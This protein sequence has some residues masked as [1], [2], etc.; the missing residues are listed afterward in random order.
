MILWENKANNICTE[1]KKDSINHTTELIFK[2][3]KFNLVCNFVLGGSLFSML[4]M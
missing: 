2:E 1:N 3:Q 4:Y